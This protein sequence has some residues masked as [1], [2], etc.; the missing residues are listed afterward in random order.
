M[1]ACANLFGATTANLSCHP[2]LK[3]Y[4]LCDMVLPIGWQWPR[5][6]MAASIAA[7]SGQTLKMGHDM[8]CS[9]T[10]ANRSNAH[11][12]SLLVISSIFAGSSNGHFLDRLAFEEDELQAHIYTTSALLCLSSNDQR[13]VSQ[14]VRLT[15]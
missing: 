2:D 14:V 6:A 8:H 1:L 12:K 3:T 9:R 5:V 10:C 15:V 4:R 13:L 7:V 11:C